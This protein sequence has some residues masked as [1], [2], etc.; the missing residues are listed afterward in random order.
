[1][2][3]GPLFYNFEL[4]WKSSMPTYRDDPKVGSNLIWTRVQKCIKYPSH[5][6][7]T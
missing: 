5:F 1:M 4:I 3:L 6:R 7:R 2:D